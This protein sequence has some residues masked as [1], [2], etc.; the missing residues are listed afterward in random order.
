MV[1][2]TSKPKRRWIRF[3][4]PAVLVAAVV[5]LF[6]YLQSD[7]FHRRVRKDVIAELDRV[8]GGR[9][10]LKGFHWSLSRL[11]FDVDDLTI[12]GLEQ[13]S[14]APYAHIDHAHLSVKILSILKRNFGLRAVDIRHPVFHLIVYADGTTNQPHPRVSSEKSYAV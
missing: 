11:E 12:H 13:P 10:E 1:Q 5:G 14:E 2:E 9:T 8:T 6:F 7:A 4:L 3:G